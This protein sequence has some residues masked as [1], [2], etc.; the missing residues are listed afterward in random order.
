MLHAL[1]ETTERTRKFHKLLFVFTL[2]TRRPP[3]PH[4][5]FY[6]QN[7]YN[8]IIKFSES[9]EN[10]GDLQPPSI[11]P[12]AHSLRIF[13]SS[14]TQSVT[15]VV[16]AMG[17]RRGRRR[18]LGARLPPGLR[19]R[20]APPCERLWWSR[21]AVDRCRRRAIT[22]CYTRIGIG[23]G[24]VDPPIGSA[25]GMLDG[26]RML[27][28]GLLLA[29]F[30]MMKIA[31]FWS[32]FR[33]RRSVSLGGYVWAGRLWCFV[34]ITYGFFHYMVMNLDVFCRRFSEYIL[35]DLL[36]FFFFFGDIFCSYF[37]VGK[38]NRDI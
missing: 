18:L 4:A 21:A 6:K 33:G 28:D 26:G 1:H 12:A 32:I 20:P 29:D 36:L 9:A 34:W 11:Y 35:S 7:P 3:P 30:R 5:R 2:R 14:V 22:S 24:C 23:D 8:F 27:G 37:V 38:N 16:G 10:S 25:Q 19:P 13:P 15:M 31:D 17:S